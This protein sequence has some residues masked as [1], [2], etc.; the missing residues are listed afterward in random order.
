M[1][2]SASTSPD[3][4]YTQGAALQLVIEHLDVARGSRNVIA[5]LSLT[6]SPGEAVLLTGANGA[7]KTT[8]I[9]AIAGYLTPASG[10]IELTPADDQ[11]LSQRCHYAGHANALKAS[12]TVRENLQFWGDY[13]AGGTTSDH[14]TGAALERLQLAALAEI[15]TAYLSAG[16]KRRAGLARILMAKR[17]VWLLDEPTVSLDAASVEI[18]ASLINE[19]TAGGGMAI[20]ATHLPLALTSPR[21]LHLSSGRGAEAA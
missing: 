16:Q 11:D 6:V 12:F 8:L 15:P 19:H 13:L 10:K 4:R 20:V 18:I 14:V 3:R 21:T 7:G 2:Q 9:R 17:P 5:D 1:R